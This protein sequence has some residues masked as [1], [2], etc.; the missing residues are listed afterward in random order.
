[1]QRIGD[2][3]HLGGHVRG[4]RPILFALAALAVPVVAQAADTR[5]PPL[6]R[7]VTVVQG[8]KV[9]VH[10]PDRRKDGMGWRATSASWPIRGELPQPSKQ[11]IN[12]KNGQVRLTWGETHRA[13]VGNERVT[14]AYGKPNTMPKRVA[15]VNVRVLPKPVSRPSG[16]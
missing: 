4:I 2:I 11:F 5:E 9:V 3:S 14:L 10:L 16:R 6:V 15:E 7:N 12:T 13:K 1:M 8:D